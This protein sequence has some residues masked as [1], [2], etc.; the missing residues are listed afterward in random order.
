[1]LEGVLV[2]QAII[3]LS[4]AL[5]GRS[6]GWVVAFWVVWT[7]VQVFA[8]WLSVVQFGTIWLAWTLFGGKK[9]TSPPSP[10]R[11]PPTPVRRQ[12]P[13]RPPPK[14][15]DEAAARREASNREV[16]QAAFERWNAEI[17]GALAEGRW[18]PSG[19]ASRLV[20]RL[21]APEWPGRTWQDAVGVGAHL[22]L[23]QAAR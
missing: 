9:D 10:S 16:F 6:R 13:P 18:V 14:L 12:D 8:L 23:T 2:W 11:P 21:P 4:I 19:T 20:T 7:I 22:K 15:M 1:M 5:S 17:K 3:F